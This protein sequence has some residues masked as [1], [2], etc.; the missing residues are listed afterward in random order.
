MCVRGSHRAARQHEIRIEPD[1][2]ISVREARATSSRSSFQ[3]ALEWLEK[4]RRQRSG[5]A[6]PP[7]ISAYVG[8][9]PRSPETPGNRI[10][11]AQKQ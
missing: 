6:A 10:N 9:G 8:I 7:Y 3:L 4:G 5:R 11:S 1:H 2:D